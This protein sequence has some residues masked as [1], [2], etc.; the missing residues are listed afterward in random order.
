MNIML[1]SR[2]SQ[3]FVRGATTKRVFSSSIGGGKK[4]PF[5]NL[6]LFFSCA[7]SLAASGVLFRDLIDFFLSDSRNPVVTMCG[8]PIRTDTT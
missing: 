3:R 4:P 7:V 6:L 2:S 5:A 8:I 1:L